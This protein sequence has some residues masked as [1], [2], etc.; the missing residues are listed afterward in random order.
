MTRPRTLL[1]RARAIPARA[2][3]SHPRR[4]G[5][6]AGDRS[7][8]ACAGLTQ[9]HPAAV[10]G[11][12]SIPACA[13]LTTGGPAPPPADPV[14]PRVRGA[15]WGRGETYSHRPGPSPRAR[16][17]LSNTAQAYAWR[18]SIPA[19]AGLTPSDGPFATGPPVHPRVRGAHGGS[20]PAPPSGRGPSPRA[21]GSHGRSRRGGQDRRSIP[22]CAGLTR[23]PGSGRVRPSV[24]PRVRGAHQEET[25][26]HGRVLGPSPRARGSRIPQGHSLTLGRSIPACAGLTPARPQ[27]ETE[28]PV[29]P[30][31][32]GAHARGEAGHRITSGPSPRA[33][34]S[35]T[36]SVA[37]ADALRSIPAC[38]GLTARTGGNSPS[39]AVHPRVRGAHV[40]AAS[41]RSLSAGPSPRARGSRLMTCGD[42][43]RYLRLII[44]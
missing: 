16:G 20:S 18:R 14:H 24:H 8:P 3:G 34:G 41:V 1:H 12:R 13:G 21:R 5:A 44:A 17:S 23:C 22:A 36:C 30:R 2:R 19:C 11:G 28:P 39:D 6:H 35:R 38:A 29:H 37:A 32:R 40:D 27:S 33:R 43:G 31:V 25:G 4:A 42:A 9:V 15:H 7:I 10:R 26:Q